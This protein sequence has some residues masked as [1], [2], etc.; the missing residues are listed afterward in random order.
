VI[1][2]LPPK[3]TFIAGFFVENILPD[4]VAAKPASD[5][6][7]RLVLHMDNAF[8]HRT[9]L[10]SQNPE[11]NGIIASRHPAFSPDLAPSDFFLFAALKGRFARCTFPSA[12]ELVEAIREITSAI[13]RGNLK[14]FF[15]NG[16][17]DCHIASALMMPMSRKLG[18]GPYDGFPS[19]LG[20]PMRRTY[21][22]PDTPFST[23]EVKSLLL[24]FGPPFF[25]PRDRHK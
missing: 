5:T 13:P 22:T 11:E 23:R 14:K 2:D 3:G 4:I 21:R 8:P 1:Q 7:H 19:L 25:S 9:L 20:L 12:D 10:T 16:K 18:I 17:R 15:S 6:H 24:R